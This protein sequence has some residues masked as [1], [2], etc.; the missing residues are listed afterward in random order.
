MQDATRFLV[1]RTEKRS[2][3]PASNMIAPAWVGRLSV[4]LRFKVD[5]RKRIRSHIRRNRTRT[6]EFIANRL[7]EHILS[8]LCSKKP[9]HKERN[10]HPTPEPPHLRAASGQGDARLRTIRFGDEQSTSSGHGSGHGNSDRNRPA[11]AAEI[12]I[13]ARI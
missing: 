6:A 8:P 12:S 2:F 9:T 4:G 5:A 7:M 11:A 1:S 3:A 13:D 10:L